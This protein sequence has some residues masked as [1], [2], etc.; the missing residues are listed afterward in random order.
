M[1]RLSGA[2]L[3]NLFRQSCHG[4]AQDPGVY[5]ELVVDVLQLLLLFGRRDAANGADSAV[6][7]NLE[8]GKHD[9]SKTRKKSLCCFS[10]LDLI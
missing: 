7:I 10:S 4:Q 2:Q 1:E 5:R 3:D 6:A 9:E 8:N